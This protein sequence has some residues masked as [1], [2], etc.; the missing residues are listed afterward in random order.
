MHASSLAA[1]AAAGSVEGQVCEFKQRHAFH[2][3]MIQR[4]WRRRLIPLDD[5]ADLPLN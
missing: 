5:W 2:L 4:I 3:R 1:L